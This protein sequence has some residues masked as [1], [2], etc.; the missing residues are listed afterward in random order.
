MNLSELWKN[1]R[2]QFLAGKRK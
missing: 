2:F 1:Y